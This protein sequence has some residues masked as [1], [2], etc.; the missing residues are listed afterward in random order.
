MN[1]Y[2]SPPPVTELPGGGENVVKPEPKKRG[3]KRKSELPVTPVA[4]KKIKYEPIDEAPDPVS[5]TIQAVAPLND[6]SPAPTVEVVIKKEPVTPV[7][8]TP[9]TDAIFSPSI[10]PQLQLTAKMETEIASPIK[11]VNSQ[12]SVK[13]AEGEVIILF[14]IIIK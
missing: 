5:A 7:K 13:S 10:T 3:R 1:L 2:P 11:P 14:Y 6:I 9:K 12:E 8:E 4:E